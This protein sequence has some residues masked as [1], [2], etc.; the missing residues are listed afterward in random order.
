MPYRRKTNRKKN[1]VALKKVLVIGALAC[2]VIVMTVLV[3]KTNLFSD[4]S[5]SSTY[6]W[7]RHDRIGYQRYREVQHRPLEA[8]GTQIE[9]RLDANSEING[10]Y[11]GLCPKN[12]VTSVESFRNLVVKDPVLSRHY[13]GF[14]WDAAKIGSQNEEVWTYVSYRK[15]ETIKRTSKPIRLPKGDRYITDGNLLVRTFCC[16]DYDL[17]SG[18]PI[19][20]AQT[21]PGSRESNPGVASNYSLMDPQEGKVPPSQRWFP[22]S[23]SNRFFADP[24]LFS[25]HPGSTRTEVPGSP[26]VPEDS[27]P[28]GVFDP[29]YNPDP[30]SVPDPPLVPDPEI[31]PDP[32]VVPEPGTI[33]LVG[34]GLGVLGIG[35]FVGKN[36]NKSL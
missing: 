10:V 13:S 16:N 36:R 15:G 25:H 18:T 26:I 22:V 3:I 5:G 21:D 27:H 12:S 2:F 8:G 30:P 23:P 24:P 35:R 1:L 28:P 33:F 34:I 4:F 6:F 9:E 32:V 20:S 11:Y 14:H 29:P 17:A 7:D 31:V 19:E